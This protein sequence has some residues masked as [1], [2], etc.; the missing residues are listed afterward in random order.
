[1]GF[2]IGLLGLVAGLLLPALSASKKVTKKKALLVIG[3]AFLLFVAGVACTPTSGKKHNAG[4][5]A[6]GETGGNGASPDNNSGGE[7][8]TEEPSPQPGQAG[9]GSKEETDPA[10]TNPAGKTTVHFIDV[11]QGDSILI[12]TPGKNILV[13]GGERGET[14]VNYLKNKKVTSLDLVVGTHPHAD[15]IGGLINVLQAIP[16]TEVIDPGVIHTTKTYEVYLTLIDEKDIK[17]TEGRAGLKRDLGDGAKL[18]L[19]HPSA[20]SGKNLNDASIV[21]KLTFG[22]VS[23]LLTGDVEQESLKQILDNYS[24]LKSTILKVSHHGSRT[25]TSSAFLAAVSPEAAVIM[26]GKGN[27]YGHPHDEVLAMLDKA[28]IKIYR[29]DLHGTIIV[30]TDG[31]TYELNIKEPYRYNPPQAPDPEPSP[32]PGT[33]PEPQASPAPVP[34][35]NPA[36]VEEDKL[37][38]ISLTETVSA[39]ETASV[40]IRGKPHTQYSITVTY[41]SG[42]SKAAGLETKTTG[43]DGRVTWSWKVG[44]R[45]TPGTYPI[46]ISGGGESI[47][48]NFTVK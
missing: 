22:D 26:A 48:V 5:P 21:I 33:S 32:A 41:K 6:A 25:G 31:R 2:F 44:T 36:P 24:R 39:G 27:T 13:D 8:D 28:E 43:A 14:V 1:M 35:P 4:P 46:T 45:T 20:P 47:T 11:G 12:Q 38:V 37:A 34:Q 19:L 40:A 15:H 16:V 17:F 3:I 42:P 9:T 23:F 29:T 7:A 18:E 10:T 30:T